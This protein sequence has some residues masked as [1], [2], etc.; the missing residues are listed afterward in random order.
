ML[1]G[2]IPAGG[3]GR[4]RPG[5]FFPDEFSCVREGSPAGGAAVTIGTNTTIRCPPAGNLASP[6]NHSSLVHEPSS[7]HAVETKKIARIAA[8]LVP[9]KKKGG[10]Q[11]GKDPAGARS[12]A[13]FSPPGSTS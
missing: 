1:P 2:V 7:R 12:Q 9:G 11:D 5:W 8:E 13:G 3:N 10:D 6:G 4:A